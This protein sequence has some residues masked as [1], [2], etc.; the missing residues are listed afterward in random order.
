MPTNTRPKKFVATSNVS[1]GTQTFAPGD[2]VPHGATLRALLVFGDKFVTED[3]P[4]RKGTT[5]TDDVG[6]NKE[7]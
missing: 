7:N 5:T 1:H 4:A 6:E 2:E 3:V